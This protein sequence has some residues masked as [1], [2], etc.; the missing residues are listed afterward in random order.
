VATGVE[1]RDKVGS[2]GGENTG[3]VVGSYRARS[4]GKELTGKG[5]RRRGGGKR[6]CGDASTAA[7]TL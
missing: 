3:G 1:R 5:Q 7:M 6:R 2:G 4:R